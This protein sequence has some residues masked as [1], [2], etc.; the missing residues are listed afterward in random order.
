MAQSWQ[1][2]CGRHEDKAAALLWLLRE[3]IPPDSP[4]LVFAA[5]R[6]H[7]EF[8]HTLLS[9]EGLRTC[10]VYGQMD[11]V[12]AL[13]GCLVHSVLSRGHCL[14]PIWHAQPHAVRRTHEA[15][16]YLQMRTRHS[17]APG[18]VSF[19]HHDLAVLH[20]LSCCCLRSA[21]RAAHPH[22]QVPGGR[23]QPDGGDGC[24]GA[25]HR[26]P[27]PGQ[28]HQLRLPRQAQ[29]LRAP[30][31]PRSPRRYGLLAFQLALQVLMVLKPSMGLQR[32]AQLQC[33]GRVQC[34]TC[35][36]ACTA[37]RSGTAYSLL[38]R[39][40]LPYLLD[41]H[42]FLSRPVHAAP[43]LSLDGAAAAAERSGSGASVYG[44]F[45][46]VGAWRCPR[47]CLCGP[48]SRRCFSCS[49]GWFA[50]RWCCAIAL[51]PVSALDAEICA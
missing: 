16:V 48:A 51:H 29:A 8:L 21:G 11:Q 40:E 2:A 14:V 46:Q 34:P 44:T 39:E 18:A 20:A 24:G 35:R 33:G 36:V 12:G 9:R 32:H 25:R 37:G 15:I 47:P 7:V 38:T 43:E 22:R 41:L 17:L 27:L 30:R 4:T 23:G 5:T 1:C 26:H 19:M 31:G 49:T 45:P 6:H 50:G 13:L 42:L 28:R 3:V 10:C